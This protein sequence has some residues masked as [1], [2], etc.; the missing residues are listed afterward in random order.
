[1]YTYPNMIDGNGICA[2]RE[3]EYE[4]VNTCTNKR[5]KRKKAATRTDFATIHH[6]H[7]HVQYDGG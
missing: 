4:N 6:V 7:F 5:E 3:N 1:M 2:A